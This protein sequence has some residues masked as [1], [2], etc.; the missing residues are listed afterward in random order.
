MNHQNHHDDVFAALRQAANEVSIKR[1]ALL[2]GVSEG[3][4]YNK[5]NPN[6]SSAHHKPTVNDLIQIVSHSDNKAP[7]EA[8]AALF[9]GV[10][11]RLPDLSKTPDEEL[12]TLVNQVGARVGGV[13]DAMAEA[14]ADLVVD[15]HEFKDFQVEVHLTI[16]AFLQL[17]ARFKTLVVQVRR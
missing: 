12:L 14:L 4:L 13:H 2:M 7:I 1:L 5:L 17:K 16:A 10:F 3:T 11:F 9:G 8:L 15:P 6:D